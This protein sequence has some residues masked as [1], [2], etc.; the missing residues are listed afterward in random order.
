M[1]KVREIQ[2]T[3]RGLLMHEYVNPSMHK[4]A[5]QIVL[6]I[7][8]TFDDNLHIKTDFIKYLTESC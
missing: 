8:D 7:C 3:I 6:W 4:V 2:T 5:L 1:P